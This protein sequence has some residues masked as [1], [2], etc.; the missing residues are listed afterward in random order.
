MVDVMVSN[1]DKQGEKRPFAA[2][3]HAVLANAG[4]AALLRGEFEPGWRWSNDVKPLTGTPSCQ[5]HHLGYVESGSMRIK[6]E[7]GTERELTAGDLFDIPPGHDAWITSDVPCVT[8]DFSADA[9]HYA[10]GRPKDIP[11]ATD[12]AMK[13]VRR[14]YEAFNAQDAETLRSLFSHDVMQHVPG[15]GPLAGTYKGVDAVLGYYGRLGELTGGT[16]RADLLEVHGDGQ[17]HVTAVHQLS[18]VRGGVKRVT[19][20]SILFTL[21]GDKI[22]DLLELHGDLPGDDAWLR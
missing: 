6:L 13:V 9:T 10:V 16:F 21:M 22:T 4:A 3:G 12:A 17:G 14:G 19:H 2:H 18:S 11:E 15:T 20:G 8:L 7:D 5:L 1:L